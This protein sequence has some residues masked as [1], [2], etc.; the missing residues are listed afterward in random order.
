LERVGLVRLNAANG[1]R[2]M[3]VEQ[4]VKL[5]LTPEQITAIARHLTPTMCDL[6]G[7]DRLQCVREALHTEQRALG[8]PQSVKIQWHRAAARARCPACRNPRRSSR[9]RLPAASIN[10]RPRSDEFCRDA[11]FQHST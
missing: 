1:V 6:S 5:V 11:P 7:A 4:R 8:H 2:Q 3:R 10:A 9:F